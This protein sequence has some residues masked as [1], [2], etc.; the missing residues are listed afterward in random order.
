MPPRKP[1]KSVFSLVMKNILANQINRVRHRVGSRILFKAEE[2]SETAAREKAG[3]IAFMFEEVRQWLDKE[4]VSLEGAHVLELGPGDT[5]GVGLLAMAHG[6][7]SVT[8]LDKFAPVVDPGFDRAVLGALRDLLDTDIQRARFDAAWDGDQLAAC[9][10][11]I[12]NCP[13]EKARRRL[14]QGHF[15][16]VWS[17]SVLE[18]LKDVPGAFTVMGGLLKPGGMMV[19]KV[20]V[21][22]DGLFSAHGHHPLHFLT[23]PAGF[24][25]LMTS[26]TYRPN[27]WQLT[28][29]RRLLQKQGWVGGV[30]P[31][32][33]VGKRSEAAP[34]PLKEAN[35]P[36]RS[37]SLVGNI[38]PRL[39]GRFAHYSDKELAVTG[40]YLV[41]RNPEIESVT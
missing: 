29:F 4:G 5:M 25:P 3:Y 34:L 14:P 8:G 23:L 12:T 40:F 37:V 22:D 41:A 9:V 13:L 18:Y 19:H 36:S 21:R 20:D 33:W 38:R 1:S 7:A 24:W 27:R 28:D 6:A 11:H 39:K 35:M 2:G 10:R 30:F 16:V 17:R 26:H 32:R 31:C 15:D